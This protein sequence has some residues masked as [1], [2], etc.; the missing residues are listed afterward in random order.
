MFEKNLSCVKQLR[1]RLLRG[2][3][4]WW[5]SD[6]VGFTTPTTVP[7]T[8]PRLFVSSRPL[9]CMLLKIEVAIF[10]A[11]T[12]AAGNGTFAER[13]AK[14]AFAG[15]A[16]VLVAEEAG[17]MDIRTI[18]RGSIGRFELSELAW[19]TSAE[20]SSFGGTVKTIENFLFSRDLA[21]G[22]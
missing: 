12:G 20:D 17:I 1:V 22:R 21:E 15:S 8:V 6:L 5:C 13:R 2:G 11:F 3:W 18:M 14:W 4:R 9:T 10:H 16:V 19:L 7:S